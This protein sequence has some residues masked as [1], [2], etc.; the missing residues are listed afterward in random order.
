MS[1][2]GMAAFSCMT[3]CSRPFKKYKRGRLCHS[4]L[5][6]IIATAE[7]S[8]TYKNVGAKADL[9]F[10]NM[11]KGAMHF[12]DEAGE[13]TWVIMDPMNGAQVNIDAHPSLLE[14][15]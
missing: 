4:D 2:L 12:F 3:L 5:L 13:A 15:E 9:Y 14:R 1:T 10:S 8:D 6:L 11:T 7:S